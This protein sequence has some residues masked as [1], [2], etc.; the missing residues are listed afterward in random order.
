MSDERVGLV[1]ASGELSSLILS[2]SIFS[3]NCCSFICAA[4]IRW[5]DSEMHNTSVMDARRISAGGPDLV[6]AAL[7]SGRPAFAAGPGN[8]PAVVDASADVEAAVSAILCVRCYVIL[9]VGS[10]HQLRKQAALTGLALPFVRLPPTPQPVQNV[11]QRPHERQARKGAPNL[12]DEHAQAEAE[13]RPL[14]SSIYVIYGRTDSAHVSQLFHHCSEQ[15]VVVVGDSTY[16]SLLSELRRRGAAV[17]S[18]D[19]AAD[20]GSALLD[21][22]GRI[23]SGLLGQSADTCAEALGLSA[24]AVPRGASV[25]AAEVSEARAGTTQE[26]CSPASCK[27]SKCFCGC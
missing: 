8:C 26:D 25:I 22:D 20:V 1:V 11:R 18:Q 13:V 21:S 5:F 3:C 4:L 9:L 2:S 14:A 7:S 23:R 24:A 15:S 19:E 16:A 6:R 12:P 27:P 17:L 10:H